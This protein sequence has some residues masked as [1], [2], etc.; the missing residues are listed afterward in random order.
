MKLILLI[1]WGDYPGISGCPKVITVSLEM[2]EEGRRKCQS[3]VMWE[4]LTIA[5]S[6][7]GRGHEPNNMGSL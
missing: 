5:V 1:Q 3:V 7:V 6:E 4:R 2:K